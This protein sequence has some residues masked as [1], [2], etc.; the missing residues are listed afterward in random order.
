MHAVLL[1]AVLALVAPPPKSVIVGAGPAGLATAIALAK[2]GWPDV[3]VFDRLKPPPRL[4]DAAT[5]SD[6]ARFYLI[7]IGG[8]GQ[9]ALRGIGAWDELE[10][11]TAV[12]R[13]RKDWAP[14]AGVDGGVETI[15]AD[16]PPSNVIQR[17][18][19]VASL[20]E[21]ATALGVTVKH[22]IDITGVSWDGDDAVLQCSPCGDECAA[23]EAG[24]RE[25]DG[26][27]EVRTS[28]LV[29]SDGV[30]RT[31]GVAMEEED[32]QRHM[33]PWRRFRIRR[34]EDTSVRVYKTVPFRP[35]ADWRRDINYS[36]RTARFN[37][38]AL[39]APSGRAD[40]SDPAAGA[41]VDE[42]CGVLLIK[43]DDEAT[44]GLADVPAARA[45]VD[46][47]LPQFSPHIS[48]AALQS[49]I[50]KE[51]SRLPVFRYA[52][53]R[54]H[55]G[56]S[57][58]LLG[59]AI[60]SVKPYFG[61]GVNSAFED[62][63]VLAEELDARESL[64]AALERYSARR[65]A[66]ARVLVQMS[67]T[68][69]LGGLRSFLSFI[70]PI[71]MDGAFGALPLL[72]RAFAPNTLAMLQRPTISFTA[73]RWRKRLDRA[74]QLAILG[75]GLTL[76]GKL[77]ARALG[78][79]ARVVLGSVLPAALA[80]PKLLALPALVAVAAGAAAFK[81]SLRGG[82]VADVLAQQTAPSASAESKEPASSGTRRGY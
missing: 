64:G 47:L 81:Q 32:R 70:G 44:Q 73:I 74:V 6:T 65:A 79:A 58:V 37:F 17:D 48:D 9:R 56:S 61:L 25:Y 24:G 33:L 77:A 16:R 30:R 13:G 18:R 1:S 43:P 51:P 20:L 21:Q 14:G 26:A 39:P 22:E 10:P 34:Y 41:P 57:T 80:R 60:H 8:R 42:Y 75:A 15:R 55:R 4:D 54:L 29:A 71:I 68:F 76:A 59:D 46:E 50:D 53:P 11:Y 82:D 19:L 7:G 78:A 5:W 3:T 62:V 69:D 45:Y 31:V 12:V 52:G 49:V 2:R 72:G 28:F 66:E 40:A 63:A 27:F 38:D 36:A 35:P 67:R 23:D